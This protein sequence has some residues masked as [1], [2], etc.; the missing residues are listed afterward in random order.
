[1][2]RYITGDIKR[3]LWFGIQPSNAADRF[4]I[5]G[6]QPEELYYWFELEDLPKVE[7][8]LESIKKTIG[9]KNL[10]KLTTFFQACTIYNDEILEKAGILDIWNKHKQNY[11]D[12]ELGTS[13]RD[14]IKEKGSCEFIAEL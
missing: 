4:G 8:E 7:K 2:G 11:A 5:I 13:I 1:M 3:K 14:C 6:T 12:Y 9:Q 10:D